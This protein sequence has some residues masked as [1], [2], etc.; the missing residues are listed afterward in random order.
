MTAH[1]HGTPI[2]PK[3]VLIELTGRCFCVPFL[4]HEQ[5]EWCH[6]NGQMVM[7]DNSAFSI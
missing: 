2:T 6:R 1:F 7:L 3:S 5:V 4:R